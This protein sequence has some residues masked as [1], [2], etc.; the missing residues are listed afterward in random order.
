MKQK[1]YSNLLLNETLKKMIPI[2]VGNTSEAISCPLQAKYK[3]K[4]SPK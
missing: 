4:C 1:S 2:T 3:A